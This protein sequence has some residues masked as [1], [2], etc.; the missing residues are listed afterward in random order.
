MTNGWPSHK[1]KTSLLEEVIAFRLAAD[2]TDEDDKHLL[3]IY[4]PYLIELL[5]EGNYS[6]RKL[7][8]KKLRDHKNDMGV[9]R[10][11]MYKCP[12][13]KDRDYYGGF[14]GGINFFTIIDDEKSLYE[15]PK[16]A[17]WKSLLMCNNCGKFYLSRNEKSDFRVGV[18]CPVCLITDP[19]E[20]KKSVEPCLTPHVWFQSFIPEYPVI[21]KK[22]TK[23]SSV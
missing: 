2:T 9:V 8:A 7:K 16:S 1:N 13:D 21:R 6:E 3:F 11:D 18:D 4:A 14:P 22:N 12:D 20:A 5:S 10:R 15:F 17:I 23:N 19:D